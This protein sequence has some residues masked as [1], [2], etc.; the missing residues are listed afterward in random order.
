MDENWG[1]PRGLES[2]ICSFEVVR[3]WLRLDPCSWWEK[4]LS[5]WNAELPMIST[6]CLGC[7]DLL[8]SGQGP[9]T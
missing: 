9:G 5:V 3:C 1:Y 6:E 4:V 2:S 7:Q 8:L